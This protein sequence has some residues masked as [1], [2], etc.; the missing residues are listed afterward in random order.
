MLELE[1]L[2]LATLS[3]VDCHFCYG[4]VMPRVL[5]L[6]SAVKRPLKNIAGPRQLQRAVAVSGWTPA[7]R[8]PQQELHCYMPVAHTAS[9]QDATNMFKTKNCTS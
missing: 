9:K 7:S 2:W 6:A 3:E 1:L 5:L 8:R 4:P